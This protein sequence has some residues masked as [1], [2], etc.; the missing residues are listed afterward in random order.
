MPDTGATAPGTGADDSAVGTITWS[1]P[2]NITADDFARANALGGSSP[3]T[4]SHY[5][6]AT[7]YGF[8]ASVPSDATIDGVEVTFRRFRTGGGTADNIVRLVVGG[9]VSGDDKAGD[10]TWTASIETAD[11]YGGSTDTWGLSLTAA[12]VRATDFGVVISATHSAAFANA[13][14]DYIPITIYYTEASTGITE[15]GT[16]R[17]VARG[18]MRGV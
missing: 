1:N 7:N 6:K 12:Q 11:T 5:L 3:P 9:T 10:N 15:R 18:V 16:A 8:D 4:T 2:G 13:F 14:V 17:G